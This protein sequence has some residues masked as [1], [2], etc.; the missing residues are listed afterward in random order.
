M[1][2]ILAQILGLGKGDSD[3]KT[4]SKM[5]IILENIEDRVTDEQNV[6]QW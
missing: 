4:T 6:L 1:S 2:L 5:Q 3:G